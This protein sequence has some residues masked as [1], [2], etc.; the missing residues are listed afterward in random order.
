MQADRRFDA[1]PIDERG[2]AKFEVAPLLTNP[3]NR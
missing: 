2:I 1:E 3:L